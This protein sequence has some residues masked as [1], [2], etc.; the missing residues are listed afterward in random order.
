MNIR[1]KKTSTTKEKK[2][3]TKRNTKSTNRIH[4]AVRQMMSTYAVGLKKALNASEWKEVLSP[5][6]S[7]TSRVT[8]TMLLDKLFTFMSDN[9]SFSDSLPIMKGFIPF[10]D[11]NGVTLRYIAFVAR[12]GFKFYDAPYV[13]AEVICPRGANVRGRG[14][15]YR[16][17]EGRHSFVYTVH[18]D[19]K[20][21][22]PADYSSDAMYFSK[23]GQ[24]CFV[25]RQYIH[26][27]NQSVLRKTVRD[28]TIL[29]DEN[30]SLIP[31]NPS[32]LKSASSSSTR[33]SSQQRLLTQI[34]REVE[35]EREA[36]LNV[37][38]R[39]RSEK[40]KESVEE[41]S[42]ASKR[43]RD[44]TVA[45]TQSVRD[46]PVRTPLSRGAFNNVPSLRLIKDHVWVGVAVNGKCEFMVLP[47]A[48]AAKMSEGAYVHD[49]FGE[50]FDAPTTA[51]TVR[52][53]SS[54]GK[55]PFIYHGQFFSCTPSTV[56]FLFSEDGPFGARAVNDDGDDDD[57]S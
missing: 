19:R 56:K 12:N 2:M 28:H 52:L 33:T 43:Q 20:T 36:E 9:K 7:S 45:Q 32:F 39:G 34:A 8:R 26:D 17:S 23:D 10:K 3:A 4:R 35:L 31:V 50:C 53:C 55:V 11:D 15:L 6:G 47:K 30:V 21:D 54:Q 27:D 5:S 25:L 49:V 16:D 24:F 40:D 44:N 51:A 37:R 1:V 14:D 13:L 57:S 41:T 48:V 22:L 46:G 29:E 42:S 38:K 18:D